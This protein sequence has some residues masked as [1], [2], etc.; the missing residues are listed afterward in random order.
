MYDDLAPSLCAY[1]A[2]RCPA[3]SDP[4]VLDLV[5]INTGWES[6]VYAFDL[7]YGP[8]EGR[9]RVPLILRIYPGEYAALKARHEHR[10]LS[11]LGAQG[12]PAPRVEA[13]EVE[14]S[15]LAGGKPFLLMERVPG[16]LM[17]RLTQSASP[18]ENARYLC[19]ASD[20]L[21][22]LHRLD[23][24]PFAQDPAAHTAP[25]GRAHLRRTIEDW[26]RMAA[27]F[28]APSAQAQLAWFSEHLGDVSPGRPAVIHLD[29]HMYNILV[30]DDGRATVIDWTCLTVSDPRV[31]LAWTMVLPS[32][33]GPA[34]R[35]ALVREYVRASG[36]PVEDLDWFYAL[37]CWRRVWSV[38]ISLLYGA[39]SV[40][41][42][43]GAE[44]A[45]RCSLPAVAGFHRTLVE[46]T[47]VEAPEV[48]GL[49]GA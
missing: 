38:A 46:A 27:P 34:L 39:G 33:G 12:Y 17:G 25:D 15:P 9:T 35:E 5:N 42:R 36:E 40:G 18:K 11:L 23:W 47:G 22:R 16:A 45:I 37:A 32:D 7:E 6:D 48:E 1:T 13:L 20:L 41:M 26:E 30:D 8:P 49:L 31:D 44:D 21:V 24:R 14:A 29:F 43:P 4:Q 19:Q 10:A 3:R 28:D 2:A